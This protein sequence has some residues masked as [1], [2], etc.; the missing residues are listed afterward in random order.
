MGGPLGKG[1]RWG[2]RKEGFAGLCVHGWSSPQRTHPSVCGCPQSL[3][4]TRVTSAAGHKCLAHLCPLTSL[5][6][7]EW[8]RTDVHRL[9]WPLEKSL[10]GST[11]AQ[12]LSEVNWDIQVADREHCPLPVRK[13]CL[14]ATSGRWWKVKEISS[15]FYYFLVLAVL[16]GLWDLSSPTKDPDRP[17]QWEHQVLTTEPAENSSTPC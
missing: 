3:V 11:R 2:A 10:P 7:S 1:G 9:T 15:P 16:R 6:T 12:H 17:R 5:G 14:V 4:C 8:Q 13:D